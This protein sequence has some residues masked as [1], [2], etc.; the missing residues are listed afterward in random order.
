MF[1]QLV[2]WTNLMWIGFLSMLKN[3]GAFRL[4][5]WL[6]NKLLLP[7]EVFF[8]FS[9]TKKCGQSTRL[10]RWK[11]H[12]TTQRKRKMTQRLKTSQ[13]LSYPPSYHL[14]ILKKQ[15]LFFISSL[16]ANYTRIVHSIFLFFEISISIL[17]HRMSFLCTVC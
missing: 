17:L 7:K 3:E 5:V 10:K 14:Q 4:R 12:G 1:G 16:G 2:V 15:D 6:K 11:D 13:P 9:S 8:K